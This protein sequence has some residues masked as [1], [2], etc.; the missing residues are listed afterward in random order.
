MNEPRRKIIGGMGSTNMP[1]PIDEIAWF[2]LTKMKTDI[3]EDEEWYYKPKRMHAWGLT[4]DTDT[5]Q[6]PSELEPK[7]N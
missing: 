2:E 7:E 1:P 4:D 6:E 3:I 5:K